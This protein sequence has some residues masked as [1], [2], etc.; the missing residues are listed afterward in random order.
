MSLLSLGLWRKYREFIN[1]WRFNDGRRM[2]THMTTLVVG[3][4]FMTLISTNVRIA[5]IGGSQAALAV[6]AG[7]FAAFTA[8]VASITLSRA[9]NDLFLAKD[10]ELIASAPVNLGEILSSRINQITFQ[11]L[12]L[13]LVFT[14]PALVLLSPHA[15][16]PSFLFFG[17]GFV[18]LQ[19]SVIT[20]VSCLGLLL[21][22]RLVP[23]RLLKQIIYVAWTVGFLALYIWTNLQLQNNEGFDLTTTSTQLGRTGLGVLAGWATRG[24]HASFYGLG[25]ESFGYLV[26]MAAVSLVAIFLSS[27]ILGRSIY[28][29]RSALGN[30]GGI[31]QR[32]GVIWVFNF[33]PVEF[34]GIAEKEFL[35]FGR[36]VRELT[37]I[38]YAL[39]LVALFAWR[40]NSLGATL[41]FAVLP[42][43]FF[44][45]NLQIR[46][47]LPAFGREG[48]QWL[49]LQ[50]SPITPRS[51]LI[52]KFIPWAILS[53]GSSLG[54]GLLLGVLAK[55]PFVEVLLCGIIGGIIGILCVVTS[56][57]L[58]ARYA[59]FSAERPE[60]YVLSTGRWGTL[61]L[62]L[63]VAGVAWLGLMPALYVR[64]WVGYIAS[65]AVII[66][67][68]A[69]TIVLVVR[70]SIKVLER[71]LSG[72]A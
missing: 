60:E 56:L 52:S 59:D 67:I 46:T 45:G 71:A 17:I 29:G 23:A 40:M 24:L 42:T 27:S 22:T 49:L 48:K 50:A 18:V 38:L 43:A 4:L 61:I 47:S 53:G 57:Y 39:T 68:A 54:L 31:V 10:F 62:T 7:N 35:T 55:L 21:L 65:L 25:W 51:L 11:N 14:F 28:A 16:S 64:S 15:A 26:L 5:L 33:I 37:G 34:R 70:A 69:L 13:A 44:A 32:R 9:L 20:A 58:G 36:D 72:D 12:P 19:V 3:L 8:L 30:Y 66:I 63:L 6:L 1:A 2:A 41:S